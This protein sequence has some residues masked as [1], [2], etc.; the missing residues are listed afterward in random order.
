MKKILDSLLTR[1][2]K[3]SVHKLIYVVGDHKLPTP[4]NKALDDD[5][6]GDLDVN[7]NCTAGQGWNI[8]LL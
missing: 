5:Y 8:N 4:V 3:V 1:H 2:G 7:K 6:G